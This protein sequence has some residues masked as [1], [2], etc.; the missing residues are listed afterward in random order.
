MLDM[1]QI[2]ERY[3]EIKLRGGT[4]LSVENPKV[5]TLKKIDGLQKDKD[6]PL[7]SLCNAVSISL[8]K[9]KQG[10]KITPEYVEEN[11]DIDEIKTIL[12]SFFTWVREVQNSPN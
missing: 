1:S 5:K 3:W 2:S 7:A 10:K 8:S 12:D 4:I 6:D 11:F 9:N